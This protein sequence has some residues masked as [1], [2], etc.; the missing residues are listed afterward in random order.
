MRLVRLGANL[1]FRDPTELAFPELGPRL[2]RL[3][4]ASGFFAHGLSL[5]SG[6]DGR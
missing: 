5:S 2:S 1:P 6:D 4:G 3:A